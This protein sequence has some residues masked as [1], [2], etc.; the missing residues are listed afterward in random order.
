MTY[1]T[2]R[3]RRHPVPKWWPSPVDQDPVDHPR[4]PAT[5]AAGL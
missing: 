1:T 5:A 3:S 4:A 2:P